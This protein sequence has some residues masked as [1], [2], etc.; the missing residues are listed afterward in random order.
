MSSAIDSE[1]S[2]IV[3]NAEKNAIDILN[4]NIDC[5]HNI[6]KA[7]LDRETISG[8]DMK[9]IIKNGSLDDSDDLN[10]ENSE[11]RTRRSTN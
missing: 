2:S 10:L 8:D 9:I 3:K 4:K 1:V 6:A 11:K 7:L 5:L